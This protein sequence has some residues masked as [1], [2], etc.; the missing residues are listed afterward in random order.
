MVLSHLGTYRSAGMGLFCE[1]C[2]PGQVRE[3]YGGEECEECPEGHYCPN[4]A[5]KYPCP[6]DAHCPAG[7]TTY[8][9]CGI[10]YQYDAADKV[11]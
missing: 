5:T 11:V 9:F 7:S 3:H 10:M 4:Q 2:K 8:T 1:H 6:L